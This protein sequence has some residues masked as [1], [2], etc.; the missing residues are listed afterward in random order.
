M[1]KLQEHELA[2]TVL[3]KAI[4]VDSRKP[5]AMVYRGIVLGKMKRHEEALNCF[6]NVCK[7]YPNNQDAF[8]Q[9]GVQL[10]ELGRHEPT[11]KN[12]CPEGG[13]CLSNT[14]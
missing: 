13:L 4:S 10:A 1:D 9:K 14:I 11:D 2:L 7:K 12:L 3:E 8:F 5:N 6:Q